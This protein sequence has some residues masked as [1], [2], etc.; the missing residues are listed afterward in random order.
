MI[1]F[2]IIFFSQ[3]D[4]QDFLD[5]LPNVLPPPKQGAAI[6]GSCKAPLRASPN[7]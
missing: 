6:K 2:V 3:L 7:N 4:A 5:D 1:Y